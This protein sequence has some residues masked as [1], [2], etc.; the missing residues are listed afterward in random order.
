MNL[1]FSH[2]ERLIVFCLSVIAYRA[3]RRI[4][5]CAHT[6]HGHIIS[7][8]TALARCPC[9]KAS[10]NNSPRIPSWHKAFSL[11]A[12][13]RAVAS[14]SSPRRDRS[15]RHCLEHVSVHLAA[16]AGSRVAKEAAPASAC[17]GLSHRPTPIVLRSSSPRCP[18]TRLLIFEEGNVATIFGSAPPRKRDGGTPD[19]IWVNMG[20]GN[21]PAATPYSFIT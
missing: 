10:L 17:V 7:S 6:S 16:L 21:P 5:R 20:G 13:P 19:L 12:T 9:H 1:V 15:H 18:N 8:Q 14:L 3:P 2:I 4:A 11:C